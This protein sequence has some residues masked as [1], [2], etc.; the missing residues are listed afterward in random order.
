MELVAPAGNFDKLYYAYTYGA[1]AAYIGLKRFSLRVKA[2]NFY[3]KEYE[4]IIDLK[5]KYPEK[6]LFCALNISF[7]NKDID[8]FIS[9]LDYFRH[10]PI[11]SFIIQDIGMVSIIQKYFPKAALHL[12][13]QANCINR[14]AVKMYKNLGFKRVVLGREASLAEISE[15][16][17]AVPEMELEVFAHGAMCIAYSGRCLMSAYMNGRSANSGFCSHS[18]RW[19]YNVLSQ[20]PKS[21]QLV[22]EEKER[23]GEYFPVFEG[24][25]FTAVLSSKDLC[26]IDYLPEM[27]AAG[28]DSLKIE[29][30]MKSIYYV[31]L[32]T[33][34][35]RKA[36]DVLE[37]KITKQ[38]A[39]PFVEELYNASHREFATGF[40]F[41]K[42]NANK[43]TTGA[44][45][46]PYELCAS[47]GNSLSDSEEKVIF[48]NA[49]LTEKKRATELETMHPAA[50]IAKEADYAAH[51]E[52]RPPIISPKTGYR[53]YTYNAMNKVA[54]KD[55][56]ANN[57]SNLL[58][59]IA[60]DVASI[61]AKDKDYQLI[62]PET[63][64]ILSWVCHGHPC[65][66]YTN[67]PLVQGMLVRTNNVRF[68]LEQ[69]R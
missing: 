32:V 30:R 22:L 11:D 44:S 45:D 51:P 48:A 15:I 68:G 49:Q 14:E 9:D 64:E 10:Y 63:G 46:S 29:G 19:E 12:S 54:S 27:K 2:D 34:A 61:S 47:I 39:A 57:A 65:L 25:D 16:K 56:N 33:R 18:C 4:K 52:K 24:E 26:M 6:K 8:N 28:V 23:P 50:R 43:T 41:S 42:E 20:L 31:A 13:T 21:G 40:F 62:N 3:E 37:G 69:H 59:F 5:K 17:D 55:C 7:H 67:L 1:D 36:L 38:Q 60:P 58:E 53:F 66:I 35:Y